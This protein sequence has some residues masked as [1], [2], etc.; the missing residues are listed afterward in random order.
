MK[1]LT[2]LAL[3]LFIALFSI[4]T[5]KA[6]K[7]YLKDAQFAENSNEP[8]TAIELYKKAYSKEKDKATKSEIVFRI[9]ECYRKILDLK[10]AETWYM[11]AIKAKYP[12]PIAILYLADMMKQNEKYA[13]AQAQY[14]NYKAANPSDKRGEDGAKS[15]ELAQKWKDNPTRYVVANEAQINSAYMDFSPCFIDRKATDLYFTSSRPGADG[16]TIDGVTGESFS[17]VYEV[18]RDKKG[19]WS[20]PT[21]ISKTINS[22]S[23]EGSISV[24]HKFD[25]L[26]FTRCPVE[27]KKNMGCEIFISEK[28]GNDWA[29]ATLVKLTTDSFSVGH[30]TLNPDETRLYFATD[31]PGGL[32]GHDIWYITYDKKAK[33]WSESPVNLGAP[34]NTEYDEMFPY[35]HEDGSLYFSSNGHLGMGGLD[36]FMAEKSGEGFSNVTNMKYPI[37]SAE[38]DFGI[39]FEGGAERGYFASNRSGGK[40]ADDIYSFVLPPLIFALQGTVKDVDTQN[41]IEGATIKLIGSDGSSVEAKTDKSGFYKFAENGAERYIKANV[42]YTLA[43]SAPR[44]LNS[45]KA[46]VTTVGVEESKTFEQAFTLKTIVKPI[47]LPNILYDLAKWDLRPES[48]VSLDG[49]IATLNENPNIT[50]QIN[51]HTDARSGDEYNDTLSQKRAQS[52]VDYLISKNIAPDRLTAKGW[53][54]RKPKPGCTEAQIAKMKTKEEQ[55]AAHQANRRT[56]FEVTSTTYVPKKQEAPAAPGGEAP[57]PG[58]EKK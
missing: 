51:S 11:K 5:T 41:P 38:D 17:D 28:K 56:E 33:V 37:N 53:G 47:E 24:T 34:I 4:T 25:K 12:D 49:L 22:P 48:M 31:M 20:T 1:H 35:C 54:E 26:F 21:P 50:I 16:N 10:Q 36:I 55:E 13:E 18:K 44:Y 8:Y 42:T 15:C 6:Q 14:N 23:N 52:V 39:M 7:N 58:G 57:A 29:E 27:K 30:P 2:V 3:S 40:G 45:E 32:G 43:A 9:A 19:K 46:K